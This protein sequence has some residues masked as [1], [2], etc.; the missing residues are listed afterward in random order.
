MR[1]A[2]RDFWFARIPSRAHNINH[3]LCRQVSANDA[4]DGVAVSFRQSLEG[5]LLLAREI[6]NDTSARLDCHFLGRMHIGGVEMARRV[7]VYHMVITWRI[8]LKERQEAAQ[9]L[10]VG[11][12]ISWV[13]ITGNRH[14]RGFSRRRRP[15]M[16]TGT[17][18]DSL[19]S[20]AVPHPSASS[21]PPRAVLQAGLQP[22]VLEAQ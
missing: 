19:P 15:Q 12:S 2:V 17:L 13:C 9:P 1:V 8:C 20:T 18:L 16:G 21:G 10:V 22:P 7:F 6:V 4:L 14:E 5:E 11:Y 3:Y